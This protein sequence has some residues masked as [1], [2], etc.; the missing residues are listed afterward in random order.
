MVNKKNLDIL[1]SELGGCLNNRVLEL[2]KE[3]RELELREKDIKTLAL[4]RS[5]LQE[6]LKPFNLQL[7]EWGGEEIRSEVKQ[8]FIQVL[9]RKRLLNVE[10]DLDQMI[11]AMTDLKEELQKGS[12]EGAGK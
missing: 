12:E 3:T 7:T 11:K 6:I 4:L 1:R 10:G 8:I 9:A 5:E 2:E